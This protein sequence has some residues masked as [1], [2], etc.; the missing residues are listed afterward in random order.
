MKIIFVL[1]LAFLFA[2]ATL[3]TSS[4]FTTITSDG[5]LKAPVKELLKILGEN[6]N[7]SPIEAEK[8]LEEKYGRKGTEERFT[9]KEK[10]ILKTKREQIKP[11]FAELGMIDAVYPSSNTFDYVI[12]L[13]ATL[14]SMRDRLRFLI[15]LIDNK[16]LTLTNKTKFYIASGDRELFSHED[17]MSS[18]LPF[19]SGWQ[20][21]GPT[22]KT[23]GEGAHWVIDQMIPSQK[24]RER[25][26]VLTAP[27]RFDEKEKKWVRPH[28]G[29]NISILLREV[30]NNIDGKKFLFISSNPYV[31][32]QL[33]VI[34]REFMDN[35]LSAR[36]I[37]VAG[38]KSSPSTKIEMLI[39]NVRN[40]I[41]RE[42]ELYERKAAL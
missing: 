21:K 16:K 38:E 34:G 36:S 35:G 29:N 7:L 2:N 15:K 42:M 19:R 4:T 5:Q 6:P 11:I 10:G 1:L 8:I 12:V 20:P 40:T 27:K 32:Y 30:G 18:A 25:F 31:Y 9:L 24:I 14:E 41:K 13:G 28:T 37:E 17:P 39:D 26:K 3:S 22:P 33:S 23:E